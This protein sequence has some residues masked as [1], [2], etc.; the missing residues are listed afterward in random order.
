MKLRCYYLCVARIE[1]YYFVLQSIFCKTLEFC[2]MSTQMYHSKYLTAGC[3]QTKTE[4]QLYSLQIT[5]S[6][7]SLPVALHFHYSL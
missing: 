1:E 4:A 5:I 6:D 2:R 7:E 3:G